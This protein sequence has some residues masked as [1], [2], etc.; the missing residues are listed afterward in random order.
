MPC[1]D[2]Q[3]IQHTYDT[4]QHTHKQRGKQHNPQNTGFLRQAEIKHGRVAMA[5]F[6]GFLVHAK[7]LTWGFPMTLDGQP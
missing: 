7:G 2:E 5:G 1:L 6:V 3:H 4:P